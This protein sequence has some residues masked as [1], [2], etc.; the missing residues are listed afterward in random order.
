MNTVFDTSGA[1]YGGPDGVRIRDTT[2]SARG[3]PGVVPSA[4]VLA[5]FGSATDDDPY[6]RAAA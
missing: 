6:L 2:D 3:G 5:A 4:A 1:G